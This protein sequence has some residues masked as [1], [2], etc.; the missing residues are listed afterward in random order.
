MSRFS[1][2][3]DTEI[4]CVRQA[5]QAH[6]L[7]RVEENTRAVQFQYSR[8]NTL[9]VENLDTM[10]NKK[11]TVMRTCCDRFKNE[12]HHPDCRAKK[13][14]AKKNRAKK[15]PG[16]LVPIVVPGMQRGPDGL[17]SSLLL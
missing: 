14:R 2:R 13:N 16:P 4:F 12:A 15:K 5:T 8:A 9:T 7:A 11:T 1:K 10:K 3:R 6:F 17:P